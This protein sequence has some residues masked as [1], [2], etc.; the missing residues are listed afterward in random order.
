MSRP[1]TPARAR[2]A[3][4]LLQEPTGITL[5]DLAHR[6]RLGKRRTLEELLELEHHGHAQRLD[7]PSGPRYLPTLTTDTQAPRP[8]SPS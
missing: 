6:A 7:T 5:H 8:K 4:I 3:R 1:R 2:V